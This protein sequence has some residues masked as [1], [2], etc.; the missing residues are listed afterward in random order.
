VG[1]EGRGLRS[2]GGRLLKAEQSGRKGLKSLVPGT[3]IHSCQSRALGAARDLRRHGA[4]PQPHTKNNLLRAP[5][6]LLIPPHPH[7]IPK[8]F[9]KVPQG[10]GGGRRRRLLR[11]V[12]VGAPRR[13]RRPPLQLPAGGVRPARQQAAVAPRGARAAPPLAGPRAA[14]GGGRARGRGRRVLA[15]W[16]GAFLGP[17]TAHKSP[18]A[19][20]RE[21]PSRRRRRH[22]AAAQV[23][24]A[25]LLNIVGAPHLAAD[26]TYRASY[27]PRRQREYRTARSDGV[28]AAALRAQEEMGYAPKVRGRARAE[29]GRPGARFR[30]R[31]GVQQAGGAEGSQAPGLCRATAGRSGP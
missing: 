7:N 29:L 23:P 24:T 12:R 11:G 31:C 16:R 2:V 5:H 17:K 22:A 28:V 14:L 30:R 8:P 9:Q 6:M 1:R 21:R 19:A 27:T 4:G 15:A 10:P 26:S 13:A 25:G 20:I 3:P 18:D